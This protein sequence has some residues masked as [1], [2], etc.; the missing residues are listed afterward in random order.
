MLFKELYAYLKFYI[1][2]KIYFKTLVF[3]YS[4]LTPDD[5][6]TLKYASF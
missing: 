2:N 3:K 4:D 6:Y 5:I 1:N